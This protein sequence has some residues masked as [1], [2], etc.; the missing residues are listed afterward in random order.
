VYTLNSEA[1]EHQIGL[2][3]AV[4]SFGEPYRRFEALAGNLT[5]VHESIVELTY[6]IKV[7]DVLTLQPDVQ[8][9]RHPGINP[10][11]N[12]AWVVGLRFEVGT[13]WSWPR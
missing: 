2:A 11:L 12:S 9:I 4:A 13:Q 8:Y 7:S 10:Q 5:H 3:I 1:R 6:R